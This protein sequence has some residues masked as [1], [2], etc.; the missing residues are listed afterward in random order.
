M[1]EK[2]KLRI[3]L[4][5]E[6]GFTNYAEELCK[7]MNIAFDKANPETIAKRKLFFEPDA[8]QVNL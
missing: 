2:N 8:D 4:L 6:L 1:P 3:K 7:I 5:A